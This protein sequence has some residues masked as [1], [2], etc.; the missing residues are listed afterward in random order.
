MSLKIAVYHYLTSTIYGIPSIQ[1][2]NQ[3]P[4]GLIA[5]DTKDQILKLLKF[6]GQKTA[7]KLKFV[8]YGNWQILNEDDEVTMESIPAGKGFLIFEDKDK[9][10]LLCTENSKL[11]LVF[12]RHLLRSVQDE[13]GIKIPFTDLGHGL[14]ELTDVEQGK[15]YNL[16][17]KKISTRRR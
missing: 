2:L 6:Y 11:H 3:F 4:D 10:T 1:Y 17:L 16:R 5:Q 7:G 14:Y 9:A 15:V 12:D 13:G 8:D